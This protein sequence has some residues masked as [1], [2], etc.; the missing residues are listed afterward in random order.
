MTC[1][2]CEELS[3]PES[4]RFA[5]MYASAFLENRIL[6]QHGEF[7]A[8]PTI[9]QLFP[10]SLLILTKSHIETMSTISEANAVDLKIFIS[11]IE[12]IIGH[13]RE[14]ILFEHGA[15]CFT[16]GGCGIYHAHMHL[17]PL[18]Y[19]IS[20]DTLLVSETDSVSFKT[21]TSLSA[22]L[23]NLQTSSEYLL[24]RDSKY[25]LKYVDISA[26]SIKK[27]PSQ[28]FRKIICESFDLDRP[29]DWR[30][31]ADQEEYVFQTIE[32]FRSSN[33]PYSN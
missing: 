27:Y 17:V 25:K 18:P 20:A 1:E 26:L 22:A 7:I 15:K 14:V 13:D 33:V 31:Y 29:W 12:K 4:S 24:V 2:F 11:N 16:G 8:I 28:Y 3:N 5:K 21:E 23:H 19:H 6:A 9:G 30:K 32:M 10:G